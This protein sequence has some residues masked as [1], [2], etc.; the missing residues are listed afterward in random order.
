LSWSELNDR[1]REVRERWPT[2]WR[3]P[4]I[5]RAA[6]HA[7]AQVRPGDRVLDVGASDGRFGRK[8][9]EG[10][11]YETLDV[12]PRVPADHR[13]LASVA[14]GSFDVV[15]CFETVEHLGL[16]EAFDLLRGIA[17]VLRPGGLLFLSTPNVHHPWSYLR[18]ATHRTPF[19]YD[20]LGGLLALAGL[21]VERLFRCHHES[22]LKRVLRPLALPLHLVLG[23][24]Y[25]KGILAVARRPRESTRPEN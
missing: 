11:R 25:A 10:A 14:D 13:D 8:L 16:D 23:V 4:V 7:A 22:V 2:I 5:P 15:A 21:P 24:D 19:C 3:L 9:P 12:D 6:R 20:E 18:S 1:R 17:R